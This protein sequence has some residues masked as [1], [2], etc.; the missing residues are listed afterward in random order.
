MGDGVGVI[1]G[2]SVGVDVPVGVPVS[3]GVSVTVGVGVVVGVCVA[4]KGGVAVGVG[5]AVW[6]AIEVGESVT[7]DV[8]D[9]SP[10]ISGKCVS[11]CWNK[12]PYATAITMASTNKRYIRGNSFL[13]HIGCRERVPVYMQNIGEGKPI[14]I[15]FTLKPVNYHLCTHQR[16][17]IAFQVVEYFYLPSLFPISPLQ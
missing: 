8:T 16:Y 12:P 2:V 14:V 5:V 10:M 1:V 11:D 4:S 13:H 15:T 9:D 3:V 17:S 7:S 6:V